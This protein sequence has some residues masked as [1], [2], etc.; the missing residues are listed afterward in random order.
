[1]VYCIFGIF[2]IQVLL[3]VF[4]GNVFGWIVDENVL[5]VLFDVFV[6]IGINFIDMVDVYLVWVFGNYG[7]ELEMII[8]KWL[9]CFGK[10]EQVVIVIKVGLFDVCVGLLKDNILKVVDDLLC[11]LQIDYIDLYFLYCDFVD[12]VLF[13][14]M[15]GVYQMLI[16]VGKVCIIGVLNYSG[17]CLCEVVVISVCDGLFVYQV[18]QF[19]YNLFDCVDYECDFELV[20]CDLKFGVVNYYVFVSGFLLGKYCSEVDLKKSVCGDCVVGYL[21]VCGLCIFVVFD[22]VLVKY[23]MQLVV[24]VF[25]WQIVWLMIIVLI[26]S[27]MLFLQFVLFGEV[28]C[29]MFDQDDICWIDEVSVF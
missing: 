17:V 9:K 29:V 23:N 21:N 20:V 22:V 14:E 11:C 26:V 13:E 18:I 16:D 3:F 6:D 24:I 5:F 4:G 19:E 10:C 25:V 27:V 2:G 1:M 12:M 15:F 7:G 8:G 28:I